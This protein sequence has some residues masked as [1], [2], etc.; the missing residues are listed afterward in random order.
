MKIYCI[1]KS[2]KLSKEPARCSGDRWGPEGLCDMAQWP[3]PHLR[4]EVEH[5]DFP[6]AGHTEV[7]AFG[8]ALHSPALKVD[9]WG[10]RDDCEKPR[11]NAPRNLYLRSRREGRWSSRMEGGGA[12][13]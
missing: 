9:L 10:L 2:D 11:L 1:Y 13:H 4:H 7:C 6:A 8:N 5:C 3:L 12:H